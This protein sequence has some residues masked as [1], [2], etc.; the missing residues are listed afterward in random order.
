MNPSEETI[1]TRLAHVHHR[2]ETACLRTGR[3]VESVRLLA[4]SKTYG[5]EAIQDAWQAGQFAF[6]ENRVQEAI[7]KAEH[8]S[9]GIQWHLIGHL[10]GNKVKL[11][12]AFFDMIH[13]VDSLKLAEAL[14]H[15][16][17]ECG[18]ILPILLQVNVA[19]ESSKFGLSP[20]NVSATYDAIGALSNLDVRGL[21]TIPPWAEDSEKS[22]PHFR[23]LRKLRDQLEKNHQATLPELSMGMSHDLEV[24]I[25]E[26]ATWVRV[27]T[28]IFGERTKTAWRPSH[29]EE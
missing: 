21:M 2:M 3:D 16:A 1:S 18:R 23:A 28:D 24:A 8:V 5:P 17:G 29:A 12:A 26:G 10:Q 14:H 15:A 7:A 11:A 4:V 19:G 22:R 6:G 20:A 13:S 25:E 9:S 27:G